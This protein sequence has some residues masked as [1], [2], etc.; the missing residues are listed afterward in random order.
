MCLKI[1]KEL[2]TWQQAE[3]EC[4]SQGAHLLSISRE[5]KE[6]SI[7]LFRH[8]YLYQ[9]KTFFIGLIATP[10][11]NGAYTYRWSDGSPFVY[12]NWNDLNF[13]CKTELCAAVIPRWR[14]EY[15]FPYRMNWFFVSCLSRNRFICGKP[16]SGSSYCFRSFLN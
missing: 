15:A 8:A 12:S 9:L 13:H 14:R 10:A 6:F 4:S 3:D 1:S 5:D 11:P 16:R 2:L 7:F